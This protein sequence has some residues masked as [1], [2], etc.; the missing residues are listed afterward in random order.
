MLTPSFH[1]SLHSAALLEDFAVPNPFMIVFPAGGT[2]ST[3][4]SN[5][6]IINDNAVE[7]DHQFT[8]NIMDTTSGSLINDPSTTI[9]TIEDDE[10]EGKLL[11]AHAIQTMNVLCSFQYWS[12]LVG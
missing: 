2:D 7:D 12:L 8:V 3:L 10:G 9:I 11:Y 6:V 1:I 4:C 5:V